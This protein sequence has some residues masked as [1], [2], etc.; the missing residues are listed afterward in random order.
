[1]SLSYVCLTNWLNLIFICIFL[2]VV[3]VQ[4]MQL[5]AT[6]RENKLNAM[7]NQLESYNFIY[8]KSNQ[9]S[10]VLMLH[11]FGVTPQIFIELQDNLGDQGWA[12]FAPMLTGKSWSLSS[13]TDSTYKEWVQTTLELYD[14]LIESYDE[15]V[16]LGFSMGGLLAYN[17]T[18]QREVD[19][20]ILLAPYFGLYKVPLFIEKCI[21]WLFRER[22]LYIKNKKLDCSLALNEAEIFTFGFTP[23]RAVAQL[24]QLA[25]TVKKS[26]DSKSSILVIHSKSD[27]VADFYKAK[28]FLEKSKKVIFKD[29]D[30]SFHYILNDVDKEQ[31][32][33]EIT[34][35]LKD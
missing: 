2:L 8:K 11:G 17:L 34:N 33:Q 22:N 13:F 28:R 7:R 9:K 30:R 1:M 15:V 14:Q 24:I 12:S 16:V 5:L 23:A 35:F 21:E 31:V 10:C 26:P 32:Y 20:C 19:R 27:H 29:L 18:L 4:F 6:L 3:A 25:Q